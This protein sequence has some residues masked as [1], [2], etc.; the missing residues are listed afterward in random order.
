ML[1]VLPDEPSLAM[2]LSH[3]L[4]HIV[5]GHKL[6][7]KL[8]FNDRM[9]FPDEDTFARL[10]FNRKESDE[11]AADKKA[12]ELINNSP[13]KEKMGTAGLFLQAVQLR[14]PALKNLIR[15]HLGSSLLEGNTARMSNLVT[16]APQLDLKKADQIAALPLGG[17]VKLDPWTNAV[18]LLKTKPVALTAPSEKMPFEVTPFFPFLTRQ[19]NGAAPDKVAALPTQK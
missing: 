14:A 8:A 17:R 12:V 9:F 1:D 2:V 15:P 19:G 16:G 5:L 10:D 11:Q 4:A 7:T 6:D 3:E 18:E 13:Y